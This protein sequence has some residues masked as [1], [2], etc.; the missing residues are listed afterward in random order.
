MTTPPEPPVARHSAE[1][2]LAEHVLPSVYR[3]ACPFGT[4]GVVHVYYL[5]TAEPAIIDTGIKQSP[6]AAIEPALAAAGFSLRAVRHVFLTHGHWDHMGGNA[7]VRAFSP[8]ATTYVHPNDQY[9]LQ[10]VS[11]HTGGYAS[12][13]ARLLDDQHALAELETSMRASI[14][15]PT[16]AEMHVAEGQAVQLGGD[17][18]MRVVHT[19]GHSL[20]STSYL[21]ENVGVLFTGDGVQGLGSRPGQ[22]PLV[23]DDSR[24]YRATLAKLSQLS[25]EALCLGHSF[26]GLS[27]GSSRA[28]VRRGPA[29]R[30]FLEESGEAAKA[31][32]EAMRSELRAGR[33]AGFTSVAQ[34]TLGTL[35]GPLQLELD[36][37]G[38]SARSL[39]TLHAF[40][41]ELTG[42]ATP[43]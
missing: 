3:I 11:A 38:L 25:I 7:S 42:A 31:V 23:F 27:P 1:A 15:C 22:L 41:R 30:A 10:D 34:R 13:A 40:Y 17:A 18:R 29:A 19:P 32:E 24:A 26:C 20:G 43:A 12:Y 37:S 14:D 5:A 39:A 33:S 21:L 4:G 35:A 16:P 28:A 36:A 2:M 6:A 8:Q 9:L